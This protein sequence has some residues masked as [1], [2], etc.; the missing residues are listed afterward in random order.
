[1]TDKSV[2]KGSRD[3]EVERA[4]SWRL[5]I[6]YIPVKEEIGE[7]V[8][9]VAGSQI[10]TLELPNP[11]KVNHTQWDTGTNEAVLLHGMNALSYC[12]RKRVF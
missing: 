3:Q 2:S 8:N 7:Q 4:C 9:K 11:T 6:P 10:F 1:M 12:D 5:L